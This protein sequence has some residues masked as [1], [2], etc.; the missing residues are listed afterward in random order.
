MTERAVHDTACEPIW[1]QKSPSAPRPLTLRRN[2]SWTLL[3]N[4][5][6]AGS[7]AG[8][9]FLLTKLGSPEAIGQYVLGL[10]FAAPL[11]MFTSLHL[12]SLQATDCRGDFGFR[13][14]LRVRIVGNL[15]ALLA[16][17]VAAIVAGYEGRTL[18]VVLL[19]AVAK[20][21]EWTADIVHGHI[22]RH[23]RMERV[24]QSTSL[25]GV[26]S[27]AAICAVAYVTGSICWGV[28][29]M[30]AA[31]LSVLIL[32]DIP[33]LMWVA[34]AERSAALRP[35]RMPLWGHL[36]SIGSR[37]DAFR[38]GGLVLTGLPL[39]GAALLGSL[40]TSIPRYFVAHY[41]GLRELGTFGAITALM[42]TGA[43]VGRALNIAVAPRLARYYANANMMAFSRLVIKLAIFYVVLG[44]V[45]VAVVPLVGEALLTILFQP[46]FAEH[47]DVLLYA[48]LGLWIAH[49]AGLTRTLLIATRRIR[50]LVPLTSLSV[51]AT[52]ILCWFLVPSHGIAG[53][54]IALAVG[55]LPAALGGILLVTL[56]ARERLTETARDDTG[57]N[58]LVNA[59][60][61]Q[62]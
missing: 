7:Q 16:V 8:V 41:E 43:N 20:C 52:L 34:G 10:T 13:D 12:R 14:Y 59:A 49:F 11:F 39:G 48:M 44:A 3:G 47:Q 9:L 1:P 40:N 29:A 46:E 35:V 21:V 61:R 24:G 6:Y 45:G 54:A 2:F 51:A 62:Q 28:V 26:L 42:L 32:F 58:I 36:I 5:V 38:L 60:L 4:A 55:K 33:S 15:F 31:R 25:H 17:A 18:V 56:A 30:I 37:W 27:C 57:R 22:Q 19:V 50:S 53:A 23:E